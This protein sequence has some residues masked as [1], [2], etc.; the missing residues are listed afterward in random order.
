[1]LRHN[2]FK[3]IIFITFRKVKKMIGRGF[4]YFENESDVDLTLIKSKL[5]K[6]KIGTI[7]KSPFSRTEFR[8]NE[9]NVGK[10]A[11]I[12]SSPRDEDGG[13]YLT[14][15]FRASKIENMHDA[16]L[17]QDKTD[18]SVFSEKVETP[19]FFFSYFFKDLIIF[20]KFTDVKHMFG[21]FLSNQLGIGIKTP[22]YDVEQ[23][24]VD[25]EP[26]KRVGGAG[27]RNRAGVAQSGAVYY[28][29]SNLGNKDV[30]VS[31]VK[32]ATKYMTRILLD[33]SGDEI[34]ANVYESGSIV[35]NQNWISISEYYNQYKSLKTILK[36]YEK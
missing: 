6:L 14:F 30:I 29:T 3:Y 15:L 25:F 23:I 13:E 26:K 21:N 18:V 5:S 2:F 28:N 8:L 24:Y 4:G 34:N 32:K 9:I 22:G 7:I 19:Y 12:T 10:I 16:V 31:E 36:P 17:N 11:D 35:L 27:F 1:M 33:I 20:S